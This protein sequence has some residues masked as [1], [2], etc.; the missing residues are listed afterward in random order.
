MEN[1]KLS[2][3]FAGKF[4]CLIIFIMLYSELFLLPS[5]RGHCMDL[6]IVFVV[7]LKPCSI[8]LLTLLSLCG[9]K[10]G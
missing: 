6:N 9:Y 5:I 7:S 1:F 2:C 10:Q 8:E 4:E 3:A